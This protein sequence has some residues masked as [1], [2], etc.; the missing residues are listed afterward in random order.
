MSW[1]VCH[2]SCLIT[3]NAKK[4]VEEAVWIIWF[5]FLVMFWKQMGML[6]VEDLSQTVMGVGTVLCHYTV[7]IV[8][9]CIVEL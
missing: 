8:L 3:S 5:S 7:D 1:S 2:T 6:D 9:Y 4:N